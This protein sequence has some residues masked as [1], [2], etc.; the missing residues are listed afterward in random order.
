[1]LCVIKEPGKEP[2]MREI[3]NT[4]KALQAAVGGHIETARI[5]GEIVC[6]MNEEGRLLGM[7]HN[8]LGFV[9]PLVFVGVQGCDFRSLTEDEAA[10]LMARI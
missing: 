3:P 1:M 2:E 8:V 6:I 7:E 9:G 5:G 4:L 10:F